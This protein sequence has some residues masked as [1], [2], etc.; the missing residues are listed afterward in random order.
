MNECFTLAHIKHECGSGECLGP[1][2]E[3][4]G[5]SAPGELQWESVLCQPGEPQAL[6][7]QTAETCWENSDCPQP[8]ERAT[9]PVEPQCS[10]KTPAGAEAAEWHCWTQLSS[11]WR[12]QWAAWHRW[13]KLPRGSF[14]LVLWWGF[15]FIFGMGRWGAKFGGAY[16]FVDKTPSLFCILLLGFFAINT[17][18]GIV[19]FS[20]LVFQ[21]ITSPSVPPSS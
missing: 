16:S 18:A 19:I 4:H 2:S 15:F 17:A 11:V 8:W 5:C 10:P 14:V 6:L 21:F 1:G 3:S 9:T 12:K 20:K 13:S 7:L